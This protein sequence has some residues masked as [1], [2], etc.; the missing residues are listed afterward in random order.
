MTGVVGP[1]RNSRQYANRIHSHT[2]ENLA[3]P[4][5]AVPNVIGVVRI[6]MLVSR[7]A[8][9]DADGVKDA[10]IRQLESELAMLRGKIGDQS[11]LNLPTFLRIS[12]IACPPGRQGR[13]P[14]TSCRSTCAGALPLVAKC[15]PEKQ[16]FTH[17]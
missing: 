9:V 3:F 16:T 7:E 8:L 4:N 6:A 11:R 5:R 13:Q 17:L 14:K 2:H 15:L 10:R 1:S 12:G